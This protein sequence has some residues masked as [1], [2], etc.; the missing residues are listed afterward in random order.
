VQTPIVAGDA[1]E[2]SLIDIEGR[3]PARNSK[4]R[5]NAIADEARLKEERQV[6]SELERVAGAR[7]LVTKETPIP[8]AEYRFVIAKWAPGQSEARCEIGF[9]G[10]HQSARGAVKAGEN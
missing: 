9:I 5:S 1:S 8:G 10:A 3:K 2:L 4:Q 7:L 6:I